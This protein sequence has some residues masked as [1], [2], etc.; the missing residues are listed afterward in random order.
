MNDPAST[1]AQTAIPPS[2]IQWLTQLKNLQGVPFNYLVPDERLL[3]PES[4]KFFLLDNTW[5]DALLDGALSIGRHYSDTAQT[6]PSLIPEQAHRNNMSS[7][8]AKALP[9]IRRRQFTG[10]LPDSESAVS[11][12]VSGFLLRSKALRAWPSMNVAAYPKGASPYDYEQ[13][14]IQSSDIQALEILRL[15]QLSSDVLIGLFDGQLYELV[16]HQP[17]EAIHFGF[18]QF[19]QQ[20]NV[21]QKS[22]RVPTTNWDD[23]NTQ[24][25]NDDPAF[26]GLQFNGIFTDNTHRVLQLSALS[27]AMGQK[28][29][30]RNIAPGYLQQTG[31]LLSS[32]FG[33]EMVQ[34]VGLVSFIN[35]T[36]A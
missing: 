28:L 2:L 27:A 35:D 21:V 33:L 15:E 7:A 26:K 36:P 31:E 17:P 10:G 24:Y 25:N 34:G 5:M 20:T 11:G 4:L 8:V 1:L 32:D 14:R 18:E 23:P 13:E 9:N 3:P 12:P 16:L 30:A 19:D 29:A 22:M 6:S